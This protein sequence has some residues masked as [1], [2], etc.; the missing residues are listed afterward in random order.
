MREFVPFEFNEKIDPGIAYTVLPSS[1]AASEVPMVPDLGPAS[2]TTRHL[3]SA[4]ISALR[5]GNA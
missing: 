2:V 3:E 4:A 1:M 5:F